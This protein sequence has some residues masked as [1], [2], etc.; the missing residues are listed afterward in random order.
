MNLR[1][2]QAFIEVVRQG[3]FSAAAKTINATQ[4][5]VSKAVKQLEDELGIT[6]LDREASPSRLTA[7]GEIV[8][9][10]ALAMLTERDDMLAEIEELRGLKR[11][12]LR[13]GLPPIG[14]SVLFAPVFAA[15][16]KLYPEIDIQ[17][18]EHGSKRLEEL[19]LAGEVELAASLLPVADS[20]E[21]QD[22]LCEPVVALMPASHPVN[23]DNGVSL[24]EISGLPFILFESGFA[25]N[26][27]ILDACRLH[28]YSPNVAVRSSQIDFIVELVAAG[29]GIGFLPGMIAEQRQHPGV[30]IHR[31]KDADVSWHMALIWRKGAFLSHAARAWLALSARQA[32]HRTS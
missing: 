7:A 30:R 28:G 22:V 10:R 23:G 32:H 27:I 21:W 26:H 14:S 5:T 15:Y 1:S 31:I 19:L 8:Y 20:F 11:G 9:R 24:R 17:L 3:G 16:T 4:S 12:L 13:L 25:L 2:F 6:L 29:M 18:V